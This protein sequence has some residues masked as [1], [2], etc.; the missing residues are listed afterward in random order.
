MKKIIYLLDVQ[1]GWCYGNSEN[2][3]EINAIFSKDVEF[4]LLVGGMLLGNQA[5]KGGE[6]FHQFIL[7]NSPRMESHTKAYV[8]PDFYKLSKDNSYTFSSYEPDAAIVAIKK[9][10][11]DK[12][13]AFTKELQRALFA[14]GKRLDVFENYVDVL[15]SLNISVEDF[16][17]EWLSDE[18]KL[19]TEMEFKKAKQLA[20]GYP[21][22]ILQDG[23]E[24]IT[25][26]AGYFEKFKMID[27][28]EMELR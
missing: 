28:L 20:N 1:C 6:Q 16:K 25:L 13:F 8:S 12:I 7:A 5:P 3:S 15:T 11:P 18:N 4:E 2:I 19:A 27:Y 22:L 17:K 21:T 23:E 24:L 26:A 14:Q 10:A 9:I